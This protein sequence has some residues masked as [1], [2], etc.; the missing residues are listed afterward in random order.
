MKS[1]RDVDWFLIKNVHKCSRALASC[2][3]G[4]PVRPRSRADWLLSIFVLKRAV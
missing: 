2:V 4:R 1:S 3:F